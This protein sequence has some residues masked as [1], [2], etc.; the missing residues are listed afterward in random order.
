MGTEHSRHPY[1]P[2]H[3]IP[4]GTVLRDVLHDKGLSQ[5]DL[6]ARTGF[7]AKHINQIVQGIAPI[8]H[9]TALSL[10]K[11]TGVPAGV[12][13]RLESSYREGLVL[14]R[15]RKALSRDLDWLRFFP[16]SELAKRNI[17]A[18]TGDKITRL[19][20]LLR[21]FGVADRTAWERIWLTPVASFRRSKAFQV[22]PGAVATWL[23]LGELE[24]QR[25]ECQ[26]YDASRFRQA[27]QK[28]RILTP[29]D[30]AISYPRIVRLCADAGVA[31]VVVKEVKG[32]RATGAARWLTP[33]KALIQLSLR[34][35]WEDI[36]WFALFH[37]AGHVLLHSKKETFIH[38]DQ[39]DEVER[40]ANQFAATALIPP[41]YESRLRSVVAPAEAKIL[42]NDLGIAPAI[43]VGRLQNERIFDWNQG[44]S[45][46]RRFDVA[47]A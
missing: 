15:E 45:L 14:E 9:D 1:A 19:E 28:I 2:D 43:V 26:L 4:P 18:S 41:A 8:T 34:H 32:C 10:E 47:G 46:R 44:N 37:E 30:P 13:N 33:T 25:L 35:K 20:Q 17:V 31:V 40:E 23:R 24:A 5:T 21:F 42:A 29:M 39:D 16:M 7:S 6:A 22:N 27:L 38:D 11:V 3:T 36:F 12:W